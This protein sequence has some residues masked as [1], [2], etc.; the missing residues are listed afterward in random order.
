MFGFPIVG[1]IAEEVLGHSLC[2]FIHRLK[3]ASY[4]WM[5]SMFL[6][7]TVLW[8]AGQLFVQL[9]SLC[10]PIVLPCDKQMGDYPCICLTLKDTSKSF[11][12]LKHC[13]RFS[14]NQRQFFR[15][16]RICSNKCCYSFLTQF[17]LMTPFLFETYNL[18][19]INLKNCILHHLKLELLKN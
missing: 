6:K 3:L 10:C 8:W 9:S 11:I 18:L 2:R 4:T 14:H 7:S 19:G 17:S 13:V 16:M 5:F 1:D 15:I 12:Y